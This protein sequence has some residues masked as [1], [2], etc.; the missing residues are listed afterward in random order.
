MV[1]RVSWSDRQTQYFSCWVLSADYWQ[2]ATKR[3]NLN[4]QF[5]APNLFKHVKNFLKTLL[6]CDSISISKFAMKSRLPYSS[7]FYLQHWTTNWTGHL[8]INTILFGFLILQRVKSPLVIIIR[9]YQQFKN[10]NVKILNFG[11]LICLLCELTDMCS[12]R[13]KLGAIYEI[14]SECILI[15]T[16]TQW[17][18]ELMNWMNHGHLESKHGSCIV[19]LCIH[20]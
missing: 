13:R 15:N 9:I 17:I 2:F 7:L 5:R 16:E 8:S 14:C 10:Q 1:S 20:M 11:F 12:K 19:L 4:P 18:S 6:P 3:R